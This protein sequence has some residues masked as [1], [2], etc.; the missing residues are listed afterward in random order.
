[1]KFLGETFTVFDG[2]A[3]KER[4]FVPFELKELSFKY[5]LIAGGLWTTNYLYAISPI[6]DLGGS[7]AMLSCLWQMYS[8]MGS[9]ISK[10]ALNR[11]GKSVTLTP[12][13]GSPKNVKIK[14]IKKLREEKELVQTYEEAFLF[15]IEV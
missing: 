14:D 3:T 6:L 15:P 4:R 10:V 2:D 7:V 12:R 11:D 9:T 1:M 5:T 13:I 8:L